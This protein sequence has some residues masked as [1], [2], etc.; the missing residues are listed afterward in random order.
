MKRRVTITNP[1]ETDVH[2][3]YEWW[4]KNR[5]DEKAK[6]WLVGIY[7]AMLQ[8]ADDADIYSGATE[9]KLRQ[10]GIKQ[11]SFGVGSRATHRI[12]YRVLA[13]EVIIFRVRAFKQDAIDLEILES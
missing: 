11:A 1:A 12:L 5:S 4:A 7:Q 9:E 10:S 6:R 2:A 3:N 13:D 8:L